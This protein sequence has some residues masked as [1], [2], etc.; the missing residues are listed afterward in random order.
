MFKSSAGSLTGCSKPT[1]KDQILNAEILQALN[2]LD[3]NHLF[4]SVNGDSDRFKK[5]VP[6]LANCCKILSVRNKIQIC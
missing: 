5:N 4:S 3:K 6:R 1:T 2:M